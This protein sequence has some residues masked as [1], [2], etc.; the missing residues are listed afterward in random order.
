MEQP[1]KQEA[2]LSAEAEGRPPRSPSHSPPLKQRLRFGEQKTRPRWAL[3][4]GTAVGDDWR[5]RG[6]R[7][8]RGEAGVQITNRKGNGFGS[9]VHSLRMSEERL[10]KKPA[11]KASS[12]LPAYNHRSQ[13]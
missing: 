1:F 2:C 6:S 12:R 8:G 4:V 9:L 3:L 13:I 11:G 5:G 10:G 7:A